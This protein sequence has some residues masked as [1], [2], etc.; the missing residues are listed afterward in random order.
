MTRLFSNQ[1]KSFVLFVTTTTLWLANPLLAQERSGRADNLGEVEGKWP[2]IILAISRIERIQENRLLVFVRVMA[3]AKSPSSGTYLSMGRPMPA[4]ADLTDVPAEDLKPFSLT[5]AVMIDEQTQ[6]RYEVLPPLASAG[7]TYLPAGF[8]NV[9]LPGEARTVSIQFAS[10]PAPPSNPG[11]EPPR[12]TV[13][14][15]LTGAKGP[16]ARVPLPPPAGGELL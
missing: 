10:P 16:I 9:L 3:T 5:S 2:G 8:S 15:L 11:K 6:R 14:F 4:G 1:M 12:Q 13:S 7:K